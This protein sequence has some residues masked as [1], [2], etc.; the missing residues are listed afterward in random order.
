MRCPITQVL[1]TTRT[2]DKSYSNT[3]FTN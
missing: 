2:E 1:A 3:N